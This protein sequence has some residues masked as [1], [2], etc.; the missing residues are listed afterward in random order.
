MSDR[1]NQLRSIAKRI[2]EINREVLEALLD[3]VSGEAGRQNDRHVAGL[4][5]EHEDLHR[6]LRLLVRDEGQIHLTG[7]DD[8]WVRKTVQDALLCELPVDQLLS[9]ESEGRAVDFTV[10]ELEPVVEEFQVWF[11]P[12]TYANRK[13]NVAVLVLRAERL[14]PEAVEFVDEMIECYAFE[15][16]TAVYAL[17]RVALESSLRSV[18]VANGLADPESGN[19]RV[20]RERGRASG[21]PKRFTN[22]KNLFSTL[23]LDDF[24]PTLDQMIRRLCYLDGY[25]S[26]V[27]PVEVTKSEPL[28]EVLD[29]IR[30]LGNSILHGNRVGDRESARVMMRDLFRTLHVLHEVQPQP[31]DDG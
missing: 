22:S 11:D 24:S 23:T 14:P 29:R 7:P 4:L 1:D 3:M 12:Y 6:R 28:E 13:L 9:G 20:V 25:Q 18:Y 31:G 16:Y 10:E 17:A 19:S 21:L 5:E 26:A 15:R 2:R 8:S 30:R 27:V